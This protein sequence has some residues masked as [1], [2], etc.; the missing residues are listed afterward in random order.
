MAPLYLKIFNDISELRHDKNVAAGLFLIGRPTLA[1]KRQSRGRDRLVISLAKKFSRGYKGFNDDRFA[2]LMYVGLME[3][4]RRIPKWDP[5]RKVTIGA[6]LKPFIHGA[7]EERIRSRLPTSSMAHT[8]D[9]KQL[10]YKNIDRWKI[11]S[12]LDHLDYI[13]AHKRRLKAEGRKARAKPKPQPDIP[14]AHGNTAGQFTA[15]QYQVYLNMH[16]P[17]PFNQTE[18]AA[19]L[20]IGRTRYRQILTDVNRICNSGLVKVKS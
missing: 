5:A 4:A 1:Q 10:V 6:Y 17:K 13:A 18:M 11:E 15:Q 20:G 19:R 16:Q 3:M 2:D 12:G 8:N 14:V 7:M 9:I